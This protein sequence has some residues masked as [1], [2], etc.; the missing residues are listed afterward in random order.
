MYTKPFLIIYLLLDIFHA[1]YKSINANTTL[2]PERNQMIHEIRLLSKWKM[3]YN[4]PR[5]LI[6]D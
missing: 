2:L 1:P 4:F 3:L 6:N 5:E